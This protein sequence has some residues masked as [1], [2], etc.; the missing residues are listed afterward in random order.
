MNR[1]K[2]LLF[3][4]SCYIFR[5]IGGFHYENKILLSLFCCYFSLD[6]LRIIAMKKLL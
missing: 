4:Y 1:K 6:I 2:K 3:A 5:G